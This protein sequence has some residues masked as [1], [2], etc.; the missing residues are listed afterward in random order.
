M[1]ITCPAS[2]APKM[3]VFSSRLAPNA[4]SPGPEVYIHTLL[5]GQILPRC[6]LHSGPSR[7]SH[8]PRKKK[9]SYS[10][11]MDS[12]SCVKSSWGRK[13]WQKVCFCSMCACSGCSSIKSDVI[14][15]PNRHGRSEA[16]ITKVTRKLYKL[17]SDSTPLTLIK[18][19]RFYPWILYIF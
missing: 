6:C 7:L 10:V 15:Q 17:F 8:P 12:E 4:A 11:P 1:L 3:G 9:K 5:N 14:M 2:A 16:T 13:H 19:S 18:S